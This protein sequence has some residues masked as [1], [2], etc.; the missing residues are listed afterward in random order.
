MRKRIRE[1][2]GDLDT[3]V[4]AYAPLG[5]VA[6]RLASARQTLANEHIEL[7]Q[8]RRAYDTCTWPFATTGYFRMKSSIPEVLERLGISGRTRNAQRASN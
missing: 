8:L 3:I 1:L 6:E 2:S 5:P 4:T 7:I